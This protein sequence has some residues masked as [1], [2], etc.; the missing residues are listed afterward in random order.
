MDNSAIAE[1]MRRRGGQLPSAAGMP[2][3]NKNPMA[4]SGQAVQRPT[5][6]AGGSPLVNQIK[7]APEDKELLIIKALIQK[8]RDMSPKQETTT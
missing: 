7:N 6:M 2:G 4:K 1:A 3:A 5:N 8:L